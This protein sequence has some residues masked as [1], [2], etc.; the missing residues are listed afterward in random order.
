MSA[1][2]GDNASVNFGTNVSV[3]QKLKTRHAGIVKANCNCHSLHNC[4]KYAL[5][6]LTFDIEE[7]V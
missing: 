7:V 2:S 3:Y 4:I 5:K 6:A 1:I